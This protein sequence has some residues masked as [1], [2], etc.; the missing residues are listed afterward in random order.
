LPWRKT[1]SDVA[2]FRR[3]QNSAASA[4]LFVCAEFF[5]DKIPAPGHDSN[6]CLN[7]SFETLVL[8]GMNID[9]AGCVAAAAEPE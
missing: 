9:Q 7:R 5:V 6:V 3:F 8:F 1:S 2:G 4:A